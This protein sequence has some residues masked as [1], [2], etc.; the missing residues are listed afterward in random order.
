MRHIHLD[1][2]LRLRFPGR[3]EDF[4]QGV[5]IGM[6]A[7]LMDQGFPEFSRWIARATLSQV[8]AIA[9]QMGYRIEEDGG[10]EE[11]VEVTFLYGT[12]KAKPKLRLVHSAG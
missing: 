11:W 5:E 4:D 2:G 10:D 1:D 8:Q 7:V 3:S 9:K 12:T 6:I